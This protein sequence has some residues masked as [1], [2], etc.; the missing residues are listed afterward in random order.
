MFTHKRAAHETWMMGN[1]CLS[2]AKMKITMKLIRYM[3]KSWA[4]MNFGLSARLKNLQTLCILSKLL[5]MIYHEQHSTLLGYTYIIQMKINI[6]L[7]QVR[8]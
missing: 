4:G 1:V 5:A 2:D 8:I 3:Y 6:V 7:M